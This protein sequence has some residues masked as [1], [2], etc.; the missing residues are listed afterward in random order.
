M[1]SIVRVV[2]NYKTA[3]LKKN[4]NNTVIPYIIKCFDIALLLLSSFFNL[5][6]LIPPLL[7]LTWKCVVNVEAVID[8]F[9]ADR[10]WAFRVKWTRALALFFA[11]YFVVKSFEDS[12]NVLR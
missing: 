3:M 8:F 10:K 5:I 1:V 9:C 7:H 11:F 6:C 12:G 2:I 4:L